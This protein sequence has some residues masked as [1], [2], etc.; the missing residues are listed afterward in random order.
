MKILIT[1]AKGQL[2]TELAK[3]AD[4]SKHELI[5]TDMEEFDLTDRLSTESF[6]NLTKPEVIINCAAYT[7]V[8]AAEM[9]AE[10]ARKVNADAPA[11]LAA[12]CAK[13][14][15]R[16]IHIST[17]YVFSGEHFVPYAESDEPDPRSVYGR[18]KLEGEQRVMMADNKAIIIR[19]AWL[20][21]P[22]GKNFVKTMLKLMTEKE[23]LKVIADQ[24]GSPTSAADL[25]RAILSLLE[26]DDVK[27]I[28]H[29]TNEGV[30]SW[31]DFAYAIAR[32]SGNKCRVLPIK[33]EEYPLPAKRPAYSVLDKSKIKNLI[34]PIRHWREALEECLEEINK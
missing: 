15:A 19:T 10:I 28:F 23:E 22:H 31:Y 8:D 21:S 2:G 6:L 30:A 14:G 24:I 27:G 5:L 16:F 34:G 7:Q 3:N 29:F 9:N 26:K 11:A 4:G 18:T 33:T 32:A 17:D 25:A 13:N 20:Y 1:G 12:W